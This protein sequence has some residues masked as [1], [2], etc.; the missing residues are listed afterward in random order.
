MN[1][2]HW[3]SDSRVKGGGLWA[4]TVEMPNVKARTKKR[5]TFEI[6]WVKLPN[7][8]IRQLEQSEHAGTYKL[9]LRIL[10]EAYKQQHIGGEVVLSAA[11]T[12]LPGTTRRSAAKELV[13]LKLIQI[14]QD[15]NRA[16]RVTQLWL[17]PLQPEDC[18]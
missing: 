2:S 9:A 13:T 10:R 12:G 11:V 4:E 18:K 15:G 8:W 1:K 3:V 17:E 7:Y 14:Q 6:E 16:T 5:K